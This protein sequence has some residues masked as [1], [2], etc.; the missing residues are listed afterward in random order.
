MPAAQTVMIGDSISDV[1]AAHA[2]SARVIGYGKTPQLAV[3]LRDSGAD[4]IVDTMADLTANLA[5]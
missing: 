1:T 4:A 2:A 3:D 5:R